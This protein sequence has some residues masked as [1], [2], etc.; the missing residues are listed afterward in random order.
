MASSEMSGMGTGADAGANAIE[1]K[2]KHPISDSRCPVLTLPIG[3]VIKSTAIV[4]LC[5]LCGNKI[6]LTGLCAVHCP[7]DGDLVETRAS[8]SV[9]RRIFDRRDT[10]ISEEIV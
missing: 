1:S 8:K 2:P 7:G 4:N 10:L 9:T 5:T 3:H 6:S